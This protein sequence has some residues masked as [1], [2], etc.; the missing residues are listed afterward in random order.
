MILGPS[1]GTV[2]FVKS[3]DDVF[4]FPL[5]MLGYS[6]NSVEPTELEVM[7]GLTLLLLIGQM[8]LVWQARRQGRRSSAAMA[9]VIAEA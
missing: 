4:I 1:S 2:V 9:G 3:R 8:I 6:L 7:L 5:K